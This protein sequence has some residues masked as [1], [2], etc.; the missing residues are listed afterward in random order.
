MYSESSVTLR[1]L[2]RRVREQLDL[3]R[4]RT[5]TIEDKP[6]LQ[7]L[8][9]SLNDMYRDLPKTSLPKPTDVDIRKRKSLS[10]RKKKKNQHIFYEGIFPF[11]F[12]HVNSTCSW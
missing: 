7:R 9:T 4:E 12:A 5:Y 3:L 1:S 2:Q 8:E 10:L 11:L 6:V